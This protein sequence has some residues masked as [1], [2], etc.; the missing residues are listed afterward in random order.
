MTEHSDPT[1]LAAAIELDAAVDAALAGRPP[2]A[3]P[4]LGL[5][6]DAH[7]PEP[8]TA[9]RARVGKVV[10][11]GERRRWLPAR[12]AAAALALAFLLEGAGNLFF[13][14]SVAR[15]LHAPFDAHTYFESGVV[16]LALAAVLVAGALAR[17]WLDLAVVAGAPVGLVLAIHGARELSEF[18]G[19][20][21]LHLS[22]GAA[23]LALALLWWRGRRYVLRTGPKR[24]HV[25]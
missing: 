9:L 13:G 5:L 23:A 25:H 18:P 7:R 17:R 14:R 19:G 4:L 3:D 20:G 22:Q 10:E 1:E 15:H 12:A 24:G 11:R 21:A 8:P 2:P 16:F 6:L